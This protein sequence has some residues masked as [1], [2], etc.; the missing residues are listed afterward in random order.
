MNSILSD[1]L[2]GDTYF[3]TQHPGHN[4]ERARNQ[5]RLVEVLEEKDE[6]LDRIIAAI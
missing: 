1:H 5:F 4:L 3:R 2:S 6:E